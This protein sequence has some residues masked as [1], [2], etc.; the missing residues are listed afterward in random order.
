MMRFR[1]QLQLLYIVAADL[2]EPRVAYFKHIQIFKLFAD[3]GLC[4]LDAKTKKNARFDAV[5]SGAR[6]FEKTQQATG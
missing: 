1:Q 2:L 6:A 4:F 3:I 5:T